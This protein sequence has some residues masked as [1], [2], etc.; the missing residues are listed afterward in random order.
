MLMVSVAPLIA[1]ASKTPPNE[2]LLGSMLAPVSTLT[3]LY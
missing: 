3:T 2:S 1:L